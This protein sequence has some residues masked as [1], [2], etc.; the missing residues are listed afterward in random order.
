[1]KLDKL[2]NDYRPSEPLVSVH[3]LIL[4]PYLVLKYRP[5]SLGSTLVFVIKI[6]KRNADR[7]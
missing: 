5:V 3:L 1:M 2:S 7:N 4:E 6:V